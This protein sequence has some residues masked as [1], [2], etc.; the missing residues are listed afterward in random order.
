[1]K[2]VIPQ[3]EKNRFA[4]SLQPGTNVVVATVASSLQVCKFGSNLKKNWKKNFHQYNFFDL[5][6]CKLD[7][8]AATATF[9]LGANLVQIYH[10]VLCVFR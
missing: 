7:A 4:L 6:P 1:M 8:I 3:D 5:Q 10:F 9:A 2:L